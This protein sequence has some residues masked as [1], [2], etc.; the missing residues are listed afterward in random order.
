MTNTYTIGGS[1]AGLT[2]GT[3]TLLDNG[4]DSLNIVGNGPFT[5]PTKVNSGSIYTVTVGTQPAGQTC[6]V[7]SGTGTASANVA[8]VAVT[9]STTTYS[10]GGT[11]SGLSSGTLTLLNNGG[12]SLN[13]VANG[14]FTFPTKIA[15]GGG[16]T[17]TVGT[18]P[19]GQTCVV[20]SGSGTAN[21]NVTN[22]AVTCTVNTYTIGGTVSGLSL[23]ATVVLQD[24]GGDNLS[25]SAS[26]PFTFA[27]KI[28]HAGF[29][30][31]TVLT[32]PAGQFCTVSPSGT[33]TALGNVSSISVTCSSNSYTVGGQIS[34]LTGTVVLQDNGGDN[35]SLSSNGAFTF[36]TPVVTG[37]AYA[38]TV[39]TQPAGQTCT[40][41]AASGTVNGGPVAGVVVTCVTN[42]TGPF[43]ISGT[44]NGPQIAGVTITLSGAASGTTTTN[45]S[46][47][48]SFAN[49]TGGLSYTV[50]A[51]LPGYSWNPSVTQPL[52]LNANTIVNFTATPS[53]AGFG[54]SGSVNYAG[55]KTGRVYVN[56]SNT[57]S[58]TS[59]VIAGGTGTFAIRGVS[60]GSYILVAHMDTGGFGNSNA[61]DPTGSSLTVTVS[62]SS[63]TGINITLTDPAVVPTPVAPTGISPFMANGAA[64]VFYNGQ[65]ASGAKGSTEQATSY[66]L[67]YGTD[68][69]AT[70]GPGSPI[71][72]KADGNSQ[73]F[74][75]SSL[76]PGASYYYAMSSLVG[77]SE[78]AKSAVVGPF[79]ASA[80]AGLSAVSGAVTFPGTA[81]GPMYVGV[82]NNTTNALVFTRIANPVSP[83]NYSVAGVANGT[84]QAVAIIDMNNDGAISAGDIANVG[85][86]SNPQLTSVAG[87]TVI[88]QTLNASTPRVTLQT[89]HATNGTPA[90]DFYQ[91]NVQLKSD[92]AGKL[93]VA[94][95]ILSAPSGPVPRDLGSGNGG[96]FQDQFFLGAA[97]P[98]IGDV[99]TLRAT[100]SDG[101]TQ[102]F[103]PAVTGV[104]SSFPQNPAAN[105]TAGN[106][107][108]PT[109]SWTA[110]AS[111]PSSYTYSIDVYSSLGGNSWY[112]PT[113]TNGMPSSQ[114]SVVYNVDGTANPAQLVTGTTYIWNISVQDSNHNNASWQSSYTP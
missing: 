56:V 4:G 47:A 58:G 89:N 7:A 114:L 71:T 72:R 77:A 87:N 37:H 60:N 97:P 54:I 113:Q 45:V 42:A 102:D 12:D 55:S 98:S 65:F 18:Q 95:E 10:I 91:E 63:Q 83:Q 1:V 28:P 34:G 52:T 50:A 86:N 69:A 104:L 15:S 44:V 41:T 22:V 93:V 39:L 81:T 76:T 84:Y 38:V 110:P 57:N 70:N 78:S 48:Y 105:P 106:R 3:V 107:N 49:L 80:S 92:T 19:T 29:Y 94:V 30:A 27:T 31:V 9:C 51:S 88:N 75:Q 24:N 6:S 35:L 40:A 46:G 26:G 36:A 103:S 68:A 73:P 20:A 90:Q 23:G 13:L 96:R 109:F 33:F 112:Y 14:G 66:K 16:Y 21:A 101:T 64:V 25:V 8:N 62:N 5:F 85:G 99:V 17:V 108:M 61:A 43:T 59:T 2:G 74:F 32:Q 100:Y 79:V 11:V 67:Y 82:Y 53:T 111:P